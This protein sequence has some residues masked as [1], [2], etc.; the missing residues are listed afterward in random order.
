MQVPVNSKY[1][2][3]APVLGCLATDSVSAEATTDVSPFASKRC[4]DA[5]ILLGSEPVKFARALCPG[6]A[7]VTKHQGLQPTIA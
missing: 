7:V 6:Q 1:S 3:Q 4:R 5:W 2:D